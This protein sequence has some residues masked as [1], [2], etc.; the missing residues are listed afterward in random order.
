MF[1]GQFLL[2]GLEFVLV[3][4]NHLPIHLRVKAAAYNTLETGMHLGHKVKWLSI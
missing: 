1:K 2:Q 3:H 4:V